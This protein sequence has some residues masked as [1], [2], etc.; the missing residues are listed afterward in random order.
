MIEHDIT[1]TCV[2]EG[3]G[4]GYIG[5]ARWQGTLLANVLRQAGIQPGARRSSCG[6][7]TA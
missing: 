1:M 7:S 2:A 6:T 5:N 4:G 3:V